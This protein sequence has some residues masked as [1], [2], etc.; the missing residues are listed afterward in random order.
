MSQKLSLDIGLLKDYVTE[1]DLETLQ[2]QVTAAYDSLLN[3]TCAGNDFLGWIDLPW[4]IDSEVDRI[5]EV[6]SEIHDKA[7]HLIS[8]GT[9]QGKAGLKA[10]LNLGEII[11]SCRAEFADNFVDFL[12]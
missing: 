6:A 11:L 4:T 7:D 1:N 9:G 2:P 10:A 12:L 5:K 3:K 8:V